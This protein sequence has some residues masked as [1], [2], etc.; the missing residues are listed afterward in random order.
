MGEIYGFNLRRDN[1]IM[2]KDV[3]KKTVEILEKLNKA[4]WEVTPVK[5]VSDRIVAY[6][7]ADGNIWYTTE[8]I[9]TDLKSVSDKKKRERMFDVEFDSDGVW[10][11]I[12]K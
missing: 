7:D 8:D 6:E 12:R 2:V 10:F 1:A 4:T 3:N 11:K 9:D 5:N